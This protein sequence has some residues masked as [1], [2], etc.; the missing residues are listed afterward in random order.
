[1]S[2]NF[3]KDRSIII[4]SVRIVLCILLLMMLVAVV[5]AG[6]TSIE[7]TYASPNDLTI[8]G[9]DFQTKT[10]PVTL[11]ATA[12]NT[13][14]FN[15]YAIGQGATG[16]AYE[17]FA[18]TM[19]DIIKLPDN[20]YRMYYGVLLS[21][22]VSGATS[23]IKSATSTDGITW[24][25]E[26]GYR[27]FGYGY[28]GESNIPANEA[29]ISGPS[30]VRLSNGNFRMYYQANSQSSGIPDFRVKSAI[31]PDG[32][33]WTREGTRIDIDYPSGSEGKF[34]LAGHCNVIRFSDNDYAIQLSGNYGPNSNTHPSDLVIGTSND[35][36]TFS[37]FS[38]LYTNGHDP[39][40]LKLDDGSGYRLF[41]G[42]LLERQRTAFSANGKSWPSQSETSETILLNST[43]GE[44]T[45]GTGEGPGDR[46]ALELAS[47]EIILFENWR[48]STSDIA[49]MR[50]QSVSPV[51]N[52]TGT[53]SSGTAPLT[54][55][56]TD[57][58]TNTPTSWSWSFGD[59]ST[60][61]SQNPSHTYTSAGTY[62]VALTA[63]NSAGSSTFTRTNYITVSSGGAAP[64]ANFT[65]T[66]TSGTAPL[67]VT[68]TDSSTNTPTSWSWSF[69]DG[70]TST[71]KNPSHTYTG[72]GSYTVAL[73]ATNAAGSNI[74]SRT[75]YIT[76]TSSSTVTY[77]WKFNKDAIGQ[78]A[79]GAAYESLAPSMPDI[80]KLPDNSYR[81]YYGANLNPPISGASS[82]IK[83]A[84]STDGLTWTVENGYRLYGYG[85]T[86]ESNIPANE[87]VVSGP[88]VVRLSNGNYRMYYQAS[89]QGVTTPPD[90][91]VKSAISSDGL[92]WTREGTRIDINYPDGGTNQFSLAGHSNVIRF[93]DNDYAIQLS[94]NYGPNSSTRPSNLV[95][96]TSNDGLTFSNFLDLYTNGHDPYVL[97]LADGS[98]YRLFYGNLLERQRTAF[99]TDGKNWP[100]QSQTTE[101][102]LLNSAGNE[103]TEASTEGPGDR[104]ALELSSGE[105]VLFVNWRS[106]NS[107]IA[108]MRQQFSTP[109]ANFVGTPTSGTT[110]LTVSFTD[111]STNTPTS[112]SWNFGD[113]SSV[114]ATV[115]NPVHTYSSAGTYTVSLTATNS[116]GSSTFTRSNYITVTSPTTTSSKIGIFRTGNFFLASSNMNG[117]GTVNAFNFGMAGDAPVTGD[118]NADGTA[119]VGIFRTGNFFLASSNIPGGGTV[120]AFN[121][122]MAGDVPVAGKWSGSGAATVGI[123]R[124]GN[125]FLASSNIPGGGT[126]NAFNFGMA[127][128]VPVAGDWDG[129]GTTTVGIFRSGNFF[130]AGS[131]IPGGGTVNAFN[132]GMAGDVPVTGDWNADGKTEVGIFRNGAVYLASSNIPG[133]GTVTAFT[134]GMAEDVPVAGKWT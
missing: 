38:I 82:A 4:D 3:V 98:G 84:T 29:V 93:A 45:E 83:S 91:R 118:W 36:L 77:T 13:W 66:P 129:D 17:S 125:F 47:G 71:E 89:T 10:D 111:N 50:Q 116:A 15:K 103:V 39:Y 18:P 105:I 11:G 119:K 130:L 33:T 49:L 54:V 12:T 124:S 123:F 96:G 31:S 121:F 14:I 92:T 101:T 8:T 30:V 102:V 67:T 6:A 90:F 51:A 37:G 74:A 35:G 72:T 95:I 75:N 24:T 99:S 114:N 64:V 5:S 81:M 128:D 65:G 117:G 44:V 63:T 43:G 133:G 56:F 27:L 80:I 21:P 7:Q 120:N 106:P 58:S 94:G 85:Y 115:K 9:T 86:G 46:S 87:G 100:S 107:D 60:S 16:T 131:N 104:T 25:V 57:S 61:T 70:I 52:F 41:Y 113:S 42:N 78:D 20:S 69:G 62:T 34:S 19:P 88:S 122:G 1:M 134:Y 26:N 73:T 28:T 126:V 97:K 110:P 48:G 53:P 32:L 108:L 112:W 59:G 40:V 68:F 22:S 132:F 2:N 23:A 76:V 127:G 79:T 109:V 55:A